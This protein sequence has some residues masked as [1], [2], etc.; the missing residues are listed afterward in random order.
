[1][2]LAIFSKKRGFDLSTIIYKACNGIYN[3]SL[4]QP[5]YFD[6]Y[7]PV[8]TMGNDFITKI[9]ANWILLFKDGK[10]YF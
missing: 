6:Q 2:G 9:S 7:Y 5:M 3:V 10:V 1:M 8:N 4:V